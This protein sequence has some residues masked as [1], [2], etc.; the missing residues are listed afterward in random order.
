MTAG[1]QHR[2]LLGSTAKLI[3]T[4]DK[5]YEAEVLKSETLC[6]VYFNAHW[7]RAVAD[8]TDTVKAEADQV[9]DKMNFCE[10][11]TVKQGNIVR[12]RHVATI[13]TFQFA[14]EGETGHQLRGK[15]SKLDLLG[16]ISAVL[17]AH[18][19]PETEFASEPSGEAEQAAPSPP[20]AAE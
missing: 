3:E 8:L 6:C 11:N 10:V 12:S 17:N 7:Y 9:G 20:E 18:G 1:G 2:P 16:K 19:A 15:V 14:K 4:T 13:P 5:N